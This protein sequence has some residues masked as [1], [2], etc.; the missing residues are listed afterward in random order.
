M[1]RAHLAGTLLS[2]FL[3]CSVAYAAPFSHVVAYGDSLSDTK[4]LFGAA[5]QPGPPA[6]SPGR[7]SNGPLAVELLSANFG[8]PLENYAWAGATTGVGNQLDR[9]DN[10][11]P[12]GTPTSFGPFGLPGMTTSFATTSGSLAPF[13]PSALFIVWGG[14]NDFLSPSPLDDT[15]VKIA[16]RA[17]DNIVGIVEGLQVLGAKHILVPGMPDLGLTPFGQANGA[18]GLSAISAYFNAN[19]RNSLPAGVRFYDTSA[20]LHQV[21]NDPATYGFTN[22]TGQCIDPSAANPTPCA[23]P[24]QYLFWDDFHTTTRAHEILAQEFADAAAVPEPATFV[25]TGCVLV[26]CG[27]ARRLRSSRAGRAGRSLVH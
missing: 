13:V 19:L 4:N 27:A 3:F 6:Y 22:V 16:N 7:A 20:L 15:S 9:L 21:V 10:K 8:V 14:P 11:S 5:G 18:A 17:V 1:K 23:N 12:G 24:N 2:S 25:L 26:L